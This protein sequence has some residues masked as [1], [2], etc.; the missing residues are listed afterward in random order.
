MTGDCAIRAVAKATGESWEQAYSHLV[1]QGYSK[2][3]L[4]NANHVW[5]AYLKAKG[6]KKAVVPDTCPDCYTVADFAADHP[7]GMYVLAL[8]NHVVAVNDGDWFDSWDSAN[9][10]VNF[11]WY[12]ED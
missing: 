7:R 3:D 10:I 2:G 1:V 5:G 4:P 12:K 6:F 9:E 11:F 8:D